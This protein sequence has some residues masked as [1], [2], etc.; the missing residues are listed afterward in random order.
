MANAADLIGGNFLE[1]IVEANNLEFR[2]L[3]NGRARTLAAAL[4]RRP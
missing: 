3:A 2:N 4:C 1:G